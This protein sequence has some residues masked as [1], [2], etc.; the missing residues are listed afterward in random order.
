[1]TRALHIALL[2]LAA[3]L[4]APAALA[5]DAPDY[6]AHYQRARDLA[7]AGETEAAGEA[8]LDA[9]TEG[10]ADFF[11]MERDGALRR[12]RDTEIYQ[13]I[14]LGWR[15]LLDARGQTDARS[16]KEAL[17][18]A[19]RIVR[20]DG[21]R[22][23]IVHARRAEAIDEALEDLRAVHRWWA[24][25]VLDALPPDLAERDPDRPD[26]WVTV[27]LPTP[28]DFVRLVGREAFAGGVGGYYDP[29]TYRLVALDLG[30]TLRHEFVHALDWRL[31]RR[32]GA[33]RPDWMLEAVASLV[34]DIDLP[35]DGDLEPTLSWR[36]NI[37]RRRVELGLRTEWPTLFD[38]PRDRFRGVRPSAQYAQ[39][40][41]IALFAWDRGAF[42]AWVVGAIE[43]DAGAALADAL[44]SPPAEAEAAFEAWLRELP[45]A[46]EAIE[47][48]GATLGLEIVR[49]RGEGARI[50]RIDPGSPARDAGLRTGDVLV[51]IGGLRVWTPEDVARVL[52]E[53]SPGE[54]VAIEAR[55][56]ARRVKTEATLVGAR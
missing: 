4:V 12:I 38:L 36:T 34:E 55:R 39:V 6:E 35:E 27:V 30:P 53:R 41:S 47:A 13:T 23:H 16:A 17:G 29:R 40:R 18:G 14:L 50:E 49:G 2:A 31:L 10:F 52:A 37:A 45:E 5:Q 46:P 32:V 15:D 1:M 43:K 48:G 25:A 7:S 26:P 51:R 22:I 11:R 3:V 20:D 42:G 28:E 8:L 19:Y 44:G 21:M 54:S 56:Y 9:I 24:E 33:R